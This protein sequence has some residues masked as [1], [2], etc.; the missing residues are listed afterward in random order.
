MHVSLWLSIYIDVVIWIWIKNYETW[1]E[2][3][4]WLTWLFEVILG[5]VVQRGS[6]GC[7]CMYYSCVYAPLELSMLVLMFEIWNKTDGVSPKTGAYSFLKPYQVDLKQMQRNIYTFQSLNG[8]TPESQLNNSHTRSTQ[9]SINT[10][11]SFEWT[12][13]LVYKWQRPS[14]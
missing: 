9:P 5:T 14:R 11:T 3:L 8:D 6:S 13:S 12:T 2:L 7:I 1:I 10:W 4:G